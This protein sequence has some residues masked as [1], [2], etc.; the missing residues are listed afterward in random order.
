MSPREKSIFQSN[1]L[2][3][4]KKITNN[5]KIKEGKPF[6]CLICNCDKETAQVVNNIYKCFEP[7]CHFSG[8]I[9]DLVRKIKPTLSKD[10]DNE[11]GEYL[12]HYLKIDVNKDLDILLSK[13]ELAGFYLFPLKPTNPNNPKEGKEPVANFKWK[14]DS[15]NNRA[16]WKNW[17]DRGYGIGLKLG[18][19][20]NVVAIDID[21]DE[22]F[23]KVK[24][25]LPNTLIQ[26]TS[27][28]SHY[29]F[30]Y[31]EDFNTINH[32]NLRTKGFDMETR[33]NNSYI[34]IAPTS[35]NGEYRSWN[36]AK[37]ID[38]PKEL[39]DFLFENINKDNINKTTADLIQEDINKNDISGA[40]LV[41]W[42]GC[43]ND[44]FVKLGGILRKKLN[45][46]GTEYALRVFNSMLEK[47][48]P[49]YA[50][51]GMV[52]Q[53]AKYKLYDKEELSK[54]VYERLSVVKEA[55]AFQ[56]SKTMGIP[57]IDVEDV[58]NHLEVEGKITSYNG[59]FR[60]A[61]TIEWKE[62]FDDEGIPVNFEVPFFNEFAYF[63]WQDLVILGSKTGGG[64]STLSANLI[65][66]FKK[67]GIKPYLINTE[68]GSRFGKYATKLG[69][70]PGDFKYTNVKTTKGLEF[71][72]NGVVILDW[73]KADGSEF[74]KIAETYANLKDQ[75]KKHNCILFCMEQLRRDNGK[76]FAE[77]LHDF[78][79]SFVASYVYGNNGVDNINTMFVT[80]KIRDSKKG[81]QVITIPTTFNVD[82]WEIELK[83]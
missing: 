53:L 1:L 60:R 75:I 78:Y 69:L 36:D 80:K 14:E 49:S 81:T 11:I 72:D 6:K 33:C 40:K 35:C 26:K 28:G 45:I 74:A 7:S 32:A 21:S 39:K 42:D 59:R 23:E 38:M 76:F 9:F 44:N 57:Q 27:R 66:A 46:E 3:Y 55:N 56:L 58:L 25:L 19:E 47:Q 31:S 16:V 12:K 20:S 5:D 4:I 34:A 54:N 30:N 8:D 71:P 62:E 13:Y 83:K 24:H 2:T 18:K 61:E 63:N 65:Y 43:R 50:I 41:G 73:L 15:S 77:N 52:G 64:K 67:Q 10:T 37:I 48:V 82:T 29:L 17:I 68:S 70:R 79:A 22:T 51:K